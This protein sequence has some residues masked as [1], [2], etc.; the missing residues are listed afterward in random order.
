[1]NT[2]NHRVVKFKNDE[3]DWY[4]ICEVYY[5]DGKVY[6]HTSEGVGVSGES[7]EELRE[8]LRRMLDCLDKEVLDEITEEQFFNKAR[9]I[10]REIDQE[11]YKVCSLEEAEA[12]AKKRE[13]HGIK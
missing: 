10:A 6:A 4:A 9:K 3:G 13:R 12:F 8:T 1:M 7:I 2:W 5:E 11:E